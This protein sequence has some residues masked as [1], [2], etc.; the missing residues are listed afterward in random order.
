MKLG[1]I[2]VT[3]TVSYG[4]VQTVVWQL[5]IALAD[6][7]HAVTVFGGEGPI[8]PDLRGRQ[9]RIETF[10]FTSRGKVL[11]LGS[12]FQRLVERRTFASHA[13]EAVSAGAFDWIVLT[14]PFDFF[15]PRLMEAGCKT[16]FAFVSGGT[17]FFVGDRW[18]A[19]GIN[20]WFACSHFNAW[21]IQSRYKRFP[22]VIYNGVNVEEFRA[23]HRDEALRRRL[24]IGDHETL[25]AFA[26]RLVGWKGLRIAISAL[27]EPALASL[28]AKLLI[29]GEGDDLAALRKRAAD[30]GVAGRVVFHPPLPHRELPAYYA[31]ADV[32]VFPSI[33]DEAFGITIAEAMAC[34]LPVIAS[35]I[36]GIPEVVGN[37]GACGL[38][39]TP[40]D[41]ADWARK[42]VE[43]AASAEERRRMGDAGARRVRDMFTWDLSAQRLLSALEV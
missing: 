23:G 37:E 27:A 43:L 20:A 2:D 38:L 10:P 22:R 36:G 12:R 35:H 17:D 3:A 6:R 28:P 7:G 18:L 4:G 41:V 42:M 5:A 8:R 31:S 30:L 40:G 11:D 16:R 9:V 24:G 14:K 19:K 39:A 25:F 13:R 32:G 15:W 21:Q 29:I 33:G 26:G 1:F 34:G